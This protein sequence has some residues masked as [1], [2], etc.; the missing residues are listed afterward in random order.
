MYST[1]IIK[2]SAVSGSIP[3]SLV[4]GEFGI[5]V[6]DGKLYYG[7][8][9]ANTVKEFGV[10][11]SYALTASYAVNTDS[12]LPPRF[13]L[14]GSEFTIKEGLQTEV[15]DLYNYGTLTLQPGTVSLPLGS[16][17][18][19][20]NPLLAINTQMYN[21]GVINNGGIIQYTINI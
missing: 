4:Q 19:T 14:S 2:N 13:I 17:F 21:N 20:N 6:T 18:I 12:G 10:T 16:I 11:A 8:S 5:N 9:S 15:Y 7:S 3:P 1:I